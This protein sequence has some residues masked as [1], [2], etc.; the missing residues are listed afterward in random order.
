MVICWPTSGTA[1]IQVSVLNGKIDISMVG[2]AG[3]N[4]SSER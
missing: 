1:Y 4:I 3:T 2:T